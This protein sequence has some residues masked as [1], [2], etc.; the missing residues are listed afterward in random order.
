VHIAVFLACIFQDYVITAEPCCA[1]C[2][3][4]MHV[5]TRSMYHR[6]KH[7]CSE[8]CYPIWRERVSRKLYVSQ[9]KLHN[10][11]D[12]LKRRN[13]TTEILWANFIS[14]CIDRTK[15]VPLHVTEARVGRGGIAHTHSRLGTKWGWVIS[16]T[17]R[18]HFSP[19]NRP[20]VP[21]EQEAGW[22]THPAW[23]QRL[24]EKSSRLCRG[25]NLDRPVVQP[26]YYTGWATPLTLSR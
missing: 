16:V 22:A 2:V 24:E 23:T 17:T 18:P 19:G 14:S 11:S 4:W 25:S 5:T 8:M 6:D 26:V 1:L 20:P 3:S 9:H 13:H 10:V 12:F 7:H 21:I 15:A